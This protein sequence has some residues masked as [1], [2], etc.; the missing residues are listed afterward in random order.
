MSLRNSLIRLAYQRPDLRAHLLPLL[1]ESVKT[2]RTPVV[3][4]YGKDLVI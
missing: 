2:A 3:P 4:S 1:G